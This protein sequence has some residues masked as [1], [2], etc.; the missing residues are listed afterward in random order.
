[1]NLCRNVRHTGA[2]YLRPPS[3]FLTSA[4]DDGANHHTHREGSFSLLGWGGLHRGVVNL[5]MML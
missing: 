5:L 4:L 1:M 2:A 3:P